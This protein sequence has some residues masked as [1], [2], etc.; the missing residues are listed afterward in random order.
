[1][2]FGVN[3]G[4]FWLCALS[5]YPYTVFDVIDPS[6]SIKGYFQKEGL[7][8]G[9]SWAWFNERQRIVWQPDTLE[10]LRAHFARWKEAT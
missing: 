6:G 2:N 4:Q 10:V 9:K 8:V 7:V 1:M 5:D 3:S